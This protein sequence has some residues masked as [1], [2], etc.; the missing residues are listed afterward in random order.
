MPSETIIVAKDLVRDIILGDG[1]LLAWIQDKVLE[2]SDIVIPFS[3]IIEGLSL[4][5]D[6]ATCGGL[7][8][9]AHL[10][11][12]SELRV[13]SKPKR[14]ESHPNALLTADLLLS[15]ILEIVDSKTIESLSRE[16]NLVTNDAF[17]VVALLCA[18]PE[19]RLHGENLANVL[20]E[21]RLDLIDP[22]KT[23]KQEWPRELSEHNIEKTR[24]K[25]F[26]AGTQ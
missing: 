5:E 10:I 1:K 14:V 17:L 3:C 20:N 23:D 11:C 26:K 2:G 6:D 19:D 15:C 4:A 7:H 8:A 24:R 25:A 16:A 13:M 9:L 18:R 21:V 22:K 12:I